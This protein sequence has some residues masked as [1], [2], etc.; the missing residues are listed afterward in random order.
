MCTEKIQQHNSGLYKCNFEMHYIWDQPQ[1]SH[2]EIFTLYNQ[3]LCQQ[4]FGKIHVKKLASPFYDDIIRN[5][6]SQR[7]EELKIFTE[8]FVKD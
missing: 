4:I 1:L 7:C 6:T 2:N 5:N 8:T 3:I